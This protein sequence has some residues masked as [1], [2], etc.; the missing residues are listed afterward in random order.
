MEKPALKKRTINFFA[1][2]GIGCIVMSLIRANQMGTF[3]PLED[4]TAK[5][6]LIIGLVSYGLS[7]VLARIM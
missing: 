2:F 7:R 1:W 4:S 5:L 6:A 3:N